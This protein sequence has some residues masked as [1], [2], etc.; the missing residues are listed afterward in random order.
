[1]P[2]KQKDFLIVGLGNPGKTYEKSRHNIGFRVVEEIAR[3]SA[4]TLRK[5][6]LINGRMARGL[7][8]EC[9][10]CLFQPGTYMNRSGEA[11]ARVMRKFG[12]DLE[13]LLVI[14]DD[15]ALPFG[16]LRLRSHSSSGGHNGLKSIEE[17]LKTNGYAR[18]R[19]GVGEQRTTDLA[20]YVLAHFT[21]DEQKLVPEILGRAAMIAKIWLTEGLTS[22]MNYANV[23]V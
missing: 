6:L 5:K 14:V 18:L 21:P 7:I 20:S 16:Q 23:K 9:N 17:N 13:N 12:I 4:L 19:I 8:E 11:V 10:V 3:E 22:A 2:P 15:V 1:L